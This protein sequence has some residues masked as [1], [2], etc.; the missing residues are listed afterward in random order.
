MCAQS[1][2]TCMYISKGEGGE[3]LFKERADPPLFLRDPLC[4][5]WY[6]ACSDSHVLGWSA[7]VPLP[8]LSL[9]LPTRK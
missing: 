7:H 6:F 3:C 9:P 8:A 5:M 2:I 1:A 4:Y